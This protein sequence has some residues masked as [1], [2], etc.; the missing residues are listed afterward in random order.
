MTSEDI[1][2]DMAKV[3]KLL[4]L[5]AQE[6]LAQDK[7]D[8]TR[9]VVLMNKH[10]RVFHNAVDNAVLYSDI[11]ETEAANIRDMAS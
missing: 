4:W 1:L 6:R 10:N 8:G 3:Q 9:A 2:M 11:T 5:F 7:R